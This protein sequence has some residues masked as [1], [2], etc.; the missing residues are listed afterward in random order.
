MGT[1]QVS[2][3]VDPQLSI[4]LEEKC[5][6]IG[7]PSLPVL[8]PVSDLFGAYLGTEPTPRAGPGRQAG[9]NGLSRPIWLVDLLV[10]LPFDM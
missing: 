1:S 5:R 3:L 2:T 4:Q 6:A 9:K 7:C 8:K 10:S